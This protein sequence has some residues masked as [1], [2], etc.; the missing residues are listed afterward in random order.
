MANP[1]V[2]FEVIG[3]DA[4]ALQ[5]F[6][7]QAFDWQMAEPLPHLN[8]AIVEPKGG[9]GINGGIG[10]GME[11]YDGH[12]TFYV[13]VPDIEAALSKIGALGGRT[14]YGPED[15]PG[16]PRIALFKDPEGHVVGLVQTP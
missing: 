4:K 6:Y 8:Y 16:G 14:M 3:K 12:A 5:T 11:G 9:N 10:A 15:V 7:K 2:H 1:V 13:G